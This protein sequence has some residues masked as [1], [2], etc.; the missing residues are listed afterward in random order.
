VR[1]RVRVR[2]EELGLGFGTAP[3]SA[4]R[5]PLGHVQMCGTLGA[6]LGVLA[7]LAFVASAPFKGERVVIGVLDL[8]WVNNATLDGVHRC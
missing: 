7:P 3:E 8:V 1:V 2:I 6:Y 5:Q 4:S